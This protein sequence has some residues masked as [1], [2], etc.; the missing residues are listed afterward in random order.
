VASAYAKKAEHQQLRK[1]RT[2]TLT[3]Q[4][5]DGAREELVEIA[6]ELHADN[7]TMDPATGNRVSVGFIRFK[8]S[9]AAWKM[10]RFLAARPRAG[11]PVVKFVSYHSKFP[12]NFLGVLDATLGQLTNRKNPT[13]FLKTPSLRAILDAHQGQDVIVIICTTTLIETGRD[14]DFDWAILEPRSVRGEVQAVGRVWR[15]RRD[16]NALMPNVVLLDRVLNSLEVPKTRAHLVKPWGMPGIEDTLPGLRVSFA[17]PSLFAPAA[18]VRPVVAARGAKPAVA[19]PAGSVATS[20]EAL[21]VKQWLEAMDAQLCILPTLAYADNRIGYLE[22]GVQDINLKKTD[23]WSRA[24]D[25]PPSVGFY[26][27]SWAPFNA[28]HATVTRF[29]GDNESTLLFIPAEKGVFYWDSKAKCRFPAPGFILEAVEGDNALIAD[30][31]E[32]AARLPE[33]SQHVVGCSLPC[34]QG[35]GHSKLGTWCPLLGFREGAAS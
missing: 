10:A 25:R 12:R 28:A 18:P 17:L 30:L 19:G 5:M 20:A 7:L 33:R 23:E 26:L 6:T 3:A 27:N 29:R 16:K 31:E 21:P 34:K 14:F 13:A 35:H 22:Q 11:G 4:K 8:T 9:R 2:W 24:S 15:H 32:Q 1:L